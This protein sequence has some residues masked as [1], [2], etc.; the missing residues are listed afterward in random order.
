M[1][2]K[3]NFFKRLTM[4]L[5][6]L[7]LYYRLRRLKAFE[8]NNKIKGIAI[9][10][11]I[12]PIL[13]FAT[14]IN[15]KVNKKSLY[16]LSDKRKKTNKPV[17]YAATHIGCSDI[18]MIFSA[19]KKHA[20]VLVGD[21]RELYRNFNGMLLDLNGVI[22]F[23]KDNKLD[24]HI[25]KETCVK[26]INQGTDLLIFPEGAWNITENLPVMGLY[27]GT[28]EIALRTGAEIIP[29]AVE[30]YKNDYYINIGKN[31]DYSGESIDNCKLLTEKLRDILATL[32]WDIWSNF[33]VKKRNCILDN[34]SQIY[35]DS[36]KE[37][38]DDSYSLSDVL[39]T[40]YCDKNIVSFKDV[41]EHLDRLTFCKEN[42][43][44]FRGK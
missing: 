5:E 2:S 37:Q 40:A 29:I 15:R 13:I 1:K 9:R 12:H 28:V 3:K 27:T 23:D 21:P 11:F 39:N 38:L 4:P 7:Q 19:I 35:I 16:I 17:I 44:L 25:G 33:S 10:K 14:S 31:I 8:E 34:Y 41:F 20:Y 24:R 22:C 36:F 32:R 18:E 26:L 42:A 43:F 6:D 30:Q